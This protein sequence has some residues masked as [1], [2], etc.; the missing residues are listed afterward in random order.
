MLNPEMYMVIM[1]PVGW[2]LFSLGG[3]NIKEQGK[4]WKGW[5]RFVLPTWVLLVLLAYGI[6]WW[7]SVMVTLLSSVFCL[8]YGETKPY[9]WKFMIGCMYASTSLPIGVSWWN[10]ATALGFIGLFAL[11]NWKVTAPT[12]TWKLCEGAFGLLYMVQLAYLLM[13]CGVTWI[14]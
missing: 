6:T 2:L 1:P 10:L 7:Q 4:G 3:T 12:F 5:R 14:R 11:S 9:W 8:G 13:G